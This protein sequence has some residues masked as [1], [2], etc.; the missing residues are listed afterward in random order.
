MIDP[1]LDN[2]VRHQVNMTQ[3]GNFVLAKM[4]RILNL[5]DADLMSQLN[6]A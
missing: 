4:I 6:A 2:A 5:S 3:Y 1:L